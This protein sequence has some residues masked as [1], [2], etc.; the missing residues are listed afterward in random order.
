MADH[1]RACGY[2]V[3]HCGT[4]ADSRKFDGGIDLKLRRG[5]EYVLVQCKHWNAYKVTHNDVHQLLGIVMNEGASGGILVNSGEF[6]KAAIEAAARLGK[7]TLIDG[8]ELR[9]M[10]GPLPEEPPPHPWPR[11]QP[12]A[13]AAGTF[14][15]NAAERLVAA[16]EHRVRHGVLRQ[17]APNAAMGALTAGLIKLAVLSILVGGFLILASTAL[18]TLGK[19]LSASPATPRASAAV[20]AASQGMQPLA[21]APFVAQPTTAP[22]RAPARATIGQTRTR[23]EQREWERRQAESMKIIEASTPEMQR[24]PVAGAE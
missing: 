24:R 3:D 15:T 1:Y 4:G 10:I 18:G 16:A 14:A 11:S 8:D 5:G 23:A 20:P 13:S 6:T 12:P 2:E 9:Q 21:Q 19:R 17:A 7:I 22:E